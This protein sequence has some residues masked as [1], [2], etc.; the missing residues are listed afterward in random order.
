MFLKRSSFG[1]WLIFSFHTLFNSVSSE[2][3]GFYIDNGIGQTIMEESIPRIDAEFLQHH[4]LELLDL[5]YRDN[6]ERLPPTNRYVKIR[7]LSIP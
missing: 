7:I 2:F 4:I 3:S 5:P 1:I 6:S